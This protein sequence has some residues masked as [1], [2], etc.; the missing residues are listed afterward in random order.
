MNSRSAQKLMSPNKQIVRPR[1]KKATAIR[2]QITHHAR[3]RPLNADTAAGFK[4]SCGCRASTCPSAVASDKSPTT[5]A[6][7]AQLSWTG[8]KVL[9]PV[10]QWLQG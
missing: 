10:Y 8:V 6:A 2:Q 7:S 5:V 1:L 9:M 3:N 4:P